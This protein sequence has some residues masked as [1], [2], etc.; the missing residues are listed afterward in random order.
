MTTLLHI[1]DTHFGT[2]Q[3]PVV[4]ALAA[5]A[6][7]LAPQLLVVSGDITQRARAAQFAAARRF[8]DRLGL[9]F[10]SIPGNHDLTV[11]NPLKRLLTPYTGYQG[12]FG[13]ELE[14]V[15]E[16]A[17]LLVQCV[18]TTRWWRHIEGEVNAAQVQ[19]VAARLRKARAEQLRVVVVHQPV[20]VE[21]QAESRHLLR[22]RDAAL[23]SWAEAGADV[24]LG[25]HIHLPYVAELTP[26]G[27][28]GAR[29]VVAQA[30][31]A[32]SSRLRR[33]APNSVNVIRHEASDATRFGIERW[34]FNGERREFQRV[35]TR[36]FERQLH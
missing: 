10:V 34:D 2:E 23:S 15:H 27:A 4:E 32:L 30:G 19:R 18:K 36:S 7:Q 12:T 17:G 1:S 26:P 13:D 9:P 22:G 25:G 24:V 11:L 35:N 3:P 20:H 21:G 31:T 28:G 8:I 16:S 6:A 29:I 5:L 33:D 14:P